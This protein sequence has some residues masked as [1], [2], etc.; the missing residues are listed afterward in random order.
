MTDSTDPTDFP[1]PPE[2]RPRLDADADR[3]PELLPGRL[4][5]RLMSHAAL[6]ERIEAA[7]FE[8]YERTPALQAARTRSDRLRLLRDTVEY[9][10]AVES[11]SLTPEARAR[12]MRDAYSQIFGYGPLDALLADA[13]VT[14]IAVEGPER[15]A[16]RYEHGELTSVGSL[17]DDDYHLRQMIGRMLAGAGAELR[18]DVPVIET[19]LDVEGRPVALTVMLPPA[20]S[21][22]S[23][24]IRV[25]PA[26]APDLKALSEGGFMTGDAAHFLAAL[27]ASPYGFI[28]VGDSES[29]KTTLL[30]ALA[31]TLPGS[32]RIAAVER[33]GELRLPAAAVRHNVVWPVADHPGSDFG[34]QVAA[35]LAEAP[36]VLVLD[37]LR[38]DEP[39]AVA[40][41]LAA[42]SAPRQLWAFRGAP[43]AKRLQAALGM[44]ARRAGQGEALVHALY[45]RLPFV[46]S[47]ARIQGRL[48]LFSIGEW[49]PT[50]LSEYPDYV[51]LYQYQNSA[52]RR[53]DRQPRRPVALG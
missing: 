11:I 32:S 8:E 26:V 16:V 15:V 25:H 12:L 6:V 22:L 1:P 40:P 38:A 20:S 51:L 7:F 24:D 31:R 3:Q 37:E 21:V 14:T 23:A 29:G 28:V 45:E 13:R 46:I 17:F 35:A 2:R 10:L 53:T 49:Q 48:Q 4:G 43:D 39:G 33:A 34:E 52:A 36:D 41:L 27:V 5:T 9:V 42:D 30:G 19:G 44:L 18:A 50:S 47:V